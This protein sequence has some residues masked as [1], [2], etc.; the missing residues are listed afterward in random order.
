MSTIGDAKVIGH[1]AHLPND[2]LCDGDAC[3]IAG[4]ELALRNYLSEMAP[5]EV[6]R[7]ILKKTRFGEI[8]RGMHR[9]GAYAFDETAYSRFYPLAKCEAVTTGSEDRLPTR[10]KNRFVRVT[11]KNIA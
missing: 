10:V 8:M 1:F 5:G 11:L 4:S 7:Y 2:V 6:G 3:I 9:G